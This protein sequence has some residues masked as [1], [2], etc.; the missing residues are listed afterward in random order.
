MEFGKIIERPKRDIGKGLLRI[1][2]Q[3]REFI[4][5]HRVVECILIWEFRRQLQRPTHDARAFAAP[6]GVGLLRWM[7][8]SGRRG[9]DVA[10]EWVDGVSQ[11]KRCQPWQETLRKLL[12]T[13]VRRHFHGRFERDGRHD[14]SPPQHLRRR[15]HWHAFLM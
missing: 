1:V 6:V 3:N 12:R 9:E 11:T 5:E 2:A 7:E 15:P 14:Y 8:F 10:L 13:W 4:E